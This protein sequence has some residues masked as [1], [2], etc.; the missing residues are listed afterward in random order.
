MAVQT[1]TNPSVAQRSLSTWWTAP[2]GVGTVDSNPV[3]LSSLP[4]TDPLVP[5]QLWVD[6]ANANAVKE[7]QG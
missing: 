6:T 1:I 4:T 2:I 5:G 3:F 7:S